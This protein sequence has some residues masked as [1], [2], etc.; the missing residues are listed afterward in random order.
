[1][2]AKFIYAGR[3]A[4]LI[5]TSHNVAVSAEVRDLVQRVRSLGV[6]GSSPI[7]L[8]AVGF[9]RR[10]EDAVE[11]ENLGRNILARYSGI[12]AFGDASAEE[13]GNLSGLEPF[14]VLRVQALIELGRRIGGAG[15]GPVTIISGASDVV[16]LLDFLQGEKRE[17][18][19]AV[20]LNSKNG[21]IRIHQVHIGTV[22]MSIVGPRE[23]FREA[24]R[25]GAASLIVAHNHPSGDP[26]PSPEDID[27]TQKLADIGAMLDIP[28]LDHVIVGERRWVSLKEK[29]IL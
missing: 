4:D 28:I 29:G 15:K 25:E 18:F 21:V 27:V 1:M 23:V 20:L 10:E 17:H 6:R 9:S 19:Y 3:F 5:V 7:D 14:E 26:T 11:G 8:V 24:I 2:L 12:Q 13:I 22:N 16:Q